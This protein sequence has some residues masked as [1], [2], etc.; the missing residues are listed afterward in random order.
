MTPYDLM[1]WSA[2]AVVSL[3]CTVLCVAM[4]GALMHLLVPPK[5]KEKPDKLRRF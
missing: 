2:A 4:I 3:F 5:D 1:M